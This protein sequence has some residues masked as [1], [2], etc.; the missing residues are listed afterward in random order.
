MSDRA[1]RQAEGRAELAAMPLPKRL[2]IIVATIAAGLGGWLLADFLQTTEFAAAGLALP[3][4]GIGALV[5]YK[6]LSGPRRNP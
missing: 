5:A 1:Q 3:V 2:A 4:V 6:R